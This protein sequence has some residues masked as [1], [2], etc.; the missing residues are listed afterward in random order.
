MIIDL[1]LLVDFGILLNR[2]IESVFT[3]WYHVRLQF[4]TCTVL[5]MRNLN[6][7]NWIWAIYSCCFCNVVWNVFSVADS[8]FEQRPLPVTAA[9][10]TT[11]PRPGETPPSFAV[12][13]SQ[14]QSRSGL[15]VFQMGQSQGAEA[16]IVLRNSMFSV[17]FIF[18]TFNS[19]WLVLCL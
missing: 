15:P 16:C 2:K 3:S 4:S 8:H 13:P 7:L 10:A 5:V 14:T 12:T 9:V 1:F 18:P 17:P 19:E 6:C 11:S